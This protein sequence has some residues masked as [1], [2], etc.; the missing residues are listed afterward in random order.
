VVERR[1]ARA[2]TAVQS[3]ADDEVKQP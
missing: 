1:I 3:P 2:V